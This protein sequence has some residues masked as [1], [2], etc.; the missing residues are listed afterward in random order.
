MI[1]VCARRT[2]LGGIGSCPMEARCAS[3]TALSVG[4]MPCSEEPAAASNTECAPLT[5]LARTQPWLCWLGPK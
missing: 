5:L 1:A 4:A 2:A 3:E